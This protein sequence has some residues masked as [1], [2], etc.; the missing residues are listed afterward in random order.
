MRVTL[1]T[2]TFFPQ[3]NGVSRTLGQLVSFLHAQ[4]DEVQLLIP[5]YA[6]GEPDSSTLAELQSFSAWRLP[7]YREIYV[8]LVG[9]RRIAAKLAKFRPQVVHVAT[10]GPLGYAAVKAARKLG[11][12]LVTSYHT[13]FSQYLECYGASIL[14][15]P[16]WK[17]LRWFHNCGRA[18]LCP[19]DSIREILV[20]HGFNDVCVWG[21]GVDCRRFAPG[22]RSEQTRSDFGVGSDETLLLYAGRVANEK[23]LPML[24]DAFL[25]TPRHLNL[26]LMI[27]GDGPIRQ[28]LMDR[29][30]DRF[31]FTGYK[32][33]DELAS[34][35]ASADLFVFPS[36]TETFGNVM[37]EAMAAGLPVLAYDVPGPKDVV[38]HG[39]TGILLKTVDAE[40]MTQA[41][42]DLTQNHELTQ[43]LAHHA[44]E[45]A[46]SQTWDKVNS[47]VR[48]T[49]I[50]NRAS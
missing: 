12:P 6:E 23:N 18:T 41:I 22:R 32:Q 21:R 40:S 42:V 17:Y 30:D 43:R 48:N 45:H 14:A 49:Y 27:V 31:I 36:L 20:D 35:Y 8:P 7:F 19:S 44:L 28:K 11:L 33:G 5:R 16:L 15:A 38:E 47:I 3:I 2:E 26:K 34:L 50:E 39:R 10:E 1:A 13:N 37:L 25:R 29:A 24:V 9:C 46:R 4:G